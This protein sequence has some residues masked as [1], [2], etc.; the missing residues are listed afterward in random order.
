MSTTPKPAEIRTARKAAG[1]TQREAAALVHRTSNEGH[2]RW[3]EWENGATT[4]PPA[5]WELFLLKTKVVDR[6]DNKK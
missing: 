4:M 6:S 5:E 2:K 3:S 1:L